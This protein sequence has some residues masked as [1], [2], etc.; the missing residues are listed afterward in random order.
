MAKAN[1]KNKSR[2]SQPTEKGP[3][4]FPS[5]GESTFPAAANCGGSSGPRVQPAWTAPPLE[6]SPPLTAGSPMLAGGWAAGVLVL[7]SPPAGGLP[8]PASL[9]PL[10]PS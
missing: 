2:D 3:R 4:S 9:P 10:D 1:V 7:R 6:P 5:D 8:S